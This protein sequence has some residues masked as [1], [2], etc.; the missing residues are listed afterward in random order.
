MKHKI[1]SLQPGQS[2]QISN[3]D[4]TKTIV[5]RSKNGNVLYHKRIQRNSVF[6]FLSESYPIYRREILKGFHSN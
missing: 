1:I 5:E 3:I 4:G 2:V 6:V